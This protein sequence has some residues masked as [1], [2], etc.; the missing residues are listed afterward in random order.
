M[1]MRMKRRR[2]SCHVRRKC[3][4]VCSM[5]RYNEFTPTQAGGAGKEVVLTVDEVRPSV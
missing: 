4:R 1:K 2:I 5:P 3:R